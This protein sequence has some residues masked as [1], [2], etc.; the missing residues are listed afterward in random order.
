MKRKRD[1]YSEMSYFLF[2]IL[3]IMNLFFLVARAV[4]IV[5]EESVKLMT[6]NHCFI[7][8][9]LAIPVNDHQPISM[10]SIIYKYD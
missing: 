9:A 4:V 7:T 8:N 5:L 10:Y 1:D 3:F 2:V 6:F